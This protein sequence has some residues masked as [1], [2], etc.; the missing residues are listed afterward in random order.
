MRTFIDCMPCFVRQSLEAIRQATDDVSMHEQML[1]RILSLTSAMDMSQSP[2]SVGRQ[3]HEWVR[4]LSGNDDPYRLIKRQFNNV[5]LG[6][7]PQLRHRIT[8]SVDPLETA[9]RLAIAGNIIDF[10]VYGS[11]QQN[12]LEKTIN[13]CLAAE[14]DIVELAEFKSAIAEVNTI[15]YLADNAGE[16]IFDRLLIEQ[17]P[18]EKITLAV[19]GSPIINDVTMEDAVTAELTSLVDVIDNGSNAPGTL[20][21]DC[22][23]EFLTRF[24]KA[25]LVIAKGQGNY[26]TLSDTNRPIYFLLKA[27]C[28]VIAN[29]LGCDVGQM[30]FQKI[31]VPVKSKEKAGI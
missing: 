31:N 20:L 8:T 15:L 2:P 9:I 5:A 18:F 22:S 4:N 17:L 13:D 16:I 24:E 21:E 30:V 14:F 28:P 11:I 1:R 27:K 7:V 10:G 25:D 29:H 26:E 12:D 23:A 3:I 6:M 19:K